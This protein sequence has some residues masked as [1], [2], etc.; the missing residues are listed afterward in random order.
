MNNQ[1]YQKSIVFCIAVYAGLIA[2]DCIQRVMLSLARHGLMSWGEYLYDSKIILVV[3]TYLAY[4]HLTNSFAELNKDFLKNL[5][6]K[7]LLF[8]VVTAI[9]TGLV[10]S[11]FPTL[12]SIYL[13]PLVL[14]FFKW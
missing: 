11:Q 6:K 8:F 13:S 14:L 4:R 10:F 7:N 5:L 2:T 9:A 1:K 3:A 12:Y